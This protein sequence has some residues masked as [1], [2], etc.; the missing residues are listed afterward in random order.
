[1]NKISC[2]VVQDIIPLYVE[3]VTSIDTNK[4]IEE[5]L[6]TCETCR[7]DYENMKKEIIVPVNKLENLQEVNYLKSFR[8][9][10]QKR[11]LFTAITSVILTIFVLFGLQ[12][13][14]FIPRIYIPYSED[15]VTIQVEQGNV[16]VSCNLPYYNGVV[17]HNSI[18]LEISKNLEKVVVIYY[19]HS[20]W[21]KY[22]K[23]LFA[24]DTI[25]EDQELVRTLLG[26]EDEITQVYYGE[27]NKKDNFYDN[28]PDIVGELDMIWRNFDE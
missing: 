16:Y 27:F 25:T 11:K 24:N 9:F 14:L 19:Y 12:V 21:T 23:P 5:H 20:P 3:E 26:N 15:Y 10:M 13:A 17:T 6:S 8:K 22:V 4:L 18:Q 1:M 2:D 7:K 28:L